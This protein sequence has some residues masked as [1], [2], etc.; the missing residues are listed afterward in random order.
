MKPISN[1]PLQ[2]GD[3]VLFEADMLHRGAASYENKTL[4]F[5]HTCPGDVNVEADVQ[6]HAGLLGSLIFGNIPTN[7]EDKDIYYN[8]I[9]MHDHSIDGSVVKIPDLLNPA[10]SKAYKKWLRKQS[11]ILNL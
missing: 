1:E 5:F 2:K 8:M 9:R 3:L 10:A 7:K 4:M 6:F 11:T